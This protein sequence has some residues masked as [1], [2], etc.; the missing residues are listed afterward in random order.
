MTTEENDIED[1]NGFRYAHLEN[2]QFYIIDKKEQHSGCWKGLNVCGSYLGLTT[3]AIWIKIKEAYQKYANEYRISIF[4]LFTILLFCFLI[5]RNVSL[6][7]N[8][9]ISRQNIKGNISY[10]DKYDIFQILL[11]VCNAQLFIYC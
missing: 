4:T 11:Y 7:A 5:L 3:L 6:Q 8:S 10:I 1:G 9:G 2:E